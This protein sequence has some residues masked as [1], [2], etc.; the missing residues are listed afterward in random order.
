MSLD[1]GEYD[2]QRSKCVHTCIEKYYFTSGILVENRLQRCR[3]IRRTVSLGPKGF[4]AD[5]C[6]YKSELSRYVV[7]CNGL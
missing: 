2:M 4:D 5:N 6:G 7:Q 1:Y 3:V